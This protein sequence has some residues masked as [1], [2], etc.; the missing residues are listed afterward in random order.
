ME[1]LGDGLVQSEQYLDFLLNRSFRHTLF[2]RQEVLVDRD[3]ASCDW[4]RLWAA[5]DATV[6]TVPLAVH[7]TPGRALPATAIGD[8]YK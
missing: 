2:C 5:T 3:Y 6:D 1:S 7:L 8:A 4:H